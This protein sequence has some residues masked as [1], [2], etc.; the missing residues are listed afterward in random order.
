MKE[1]IRGQK[2]EVYRK[3]VEDQIKSNNRDKQMLNQSEEEDYAKMI[4]QWK[5]RMEVD[6]KEAINPIDRWH[7][8][9]QEKSQTSSLN[10]C[11]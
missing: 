1:T 11:Q 10:L 8:A 9:R 6:R 4:R 3:A 2:K 5:M 7:R